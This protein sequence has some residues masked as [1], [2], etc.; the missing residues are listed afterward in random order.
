MLIGAIHQGFKFAYKIL[1]KE[2]GTCGINFTIF[3]IFF[4]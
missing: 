1:K 4:E 2:K 3:D